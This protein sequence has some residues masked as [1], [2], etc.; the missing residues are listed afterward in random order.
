MTVK[1]GQQ[2]SAMTDDIAGYKVVT[3]VLTDSCS[4]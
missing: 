2:A 3:H 4:T 1:V